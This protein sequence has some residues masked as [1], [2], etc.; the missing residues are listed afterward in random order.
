M[1]EVNCLM[2]RGGGAPAREPVV[3]EEEQKNMMAYYYRK[4]EEFKVQTM[5]SKQTCM[6]HVHFLWSTYSGEKFIALLAIIIGAPIVCVGMLD[7]MICLPPR[8]G[9]VLA[10][11]KI[12]YMKMVGG[13]Q[14]LGPAKLLQLLHLYGPSWAVTP[15]PI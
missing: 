10:W 6:S 8:P 5:I 3:S 13:V 9:M 15:A 4:Q 7:S 2:Q 12:G 1:N 14:N 11:G